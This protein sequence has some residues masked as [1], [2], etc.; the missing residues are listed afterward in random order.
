MSPLWFLTLPCLAA[1]LL[2]PRALAKG[3]KAVAED[4]ADCRDVSGGVQ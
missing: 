2:I 3:R 4:W 1:A